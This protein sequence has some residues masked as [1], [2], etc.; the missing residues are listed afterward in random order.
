MNN[1]FEIIKM[2]NNP[3]DF[4]LN[5]FKNNSDPILKN[6]IEM[7]ESNNR[8]GIEQFA[9]NMCKEKNIDFDKE[10]NGLLGM[11]K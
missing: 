5:Q 6:L 4:V 3:R 7:A 10:F 1:F 9:R 8:Q 2:I 11:I